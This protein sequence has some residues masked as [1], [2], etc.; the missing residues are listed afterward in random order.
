MSEKDYLNKVEE[1]LKQHEYFLLGKTWCPDVKYAIAKLK[2]QGL[3]AKFEVYNLD[4]IK[5]Q[6]EASKIER[7][8]TQVAGKKWV[9]SIFVSGKYWGNEQTI[10]EKLSRGEK[11][12]F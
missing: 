1:L 11:L 7:A 2:E 10:K 8:F 6:D 4:L 12:E 9:P 5:D 3:F